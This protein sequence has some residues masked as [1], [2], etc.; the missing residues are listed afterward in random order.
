MPDL[1]AIG[2]GLNAAK[3]LFDIGKTM[4]GLR[5]SAQ[6]LEATVEFNQ[7]LLTVQRA[8]LDAQAEQTALVQ[9]ISAL[10]K[11]I[12]DLKALDH[13]KEKYEL[14]KV[15]RGIAYTLKPEAQGTEP[16]HFIC[17]QCYDD[18][19]RSIMQNF[20]PATPPAYKC[21]RCGN[22]FLT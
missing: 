11:E 1:I 7:Q 14:K 6:L 9:N 8:L 19:K 12:A 18:G 17:A 3:A 22:T 2:Q 20:N 4:L 16:P 15:R 21:N 13:E 5:D 10:E